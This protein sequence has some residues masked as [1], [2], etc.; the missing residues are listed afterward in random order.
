[1]KILQISKL[2][3]IQEIIESKI[4]ISKLVEIF[5]NS[6]NDWPN[7]VVSLEDFELDVQNIIRTDVTQ[8]SLEIFLSEIN[9][10]KNAW[11]AESLSQLIHIFDYYN[12]KVSLKEII[13]DLK[14]KLYCENLI[15]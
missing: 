6:I 15:D 2:I 14:Q 7:S 3:E 11:Q 10:T 12:D 4:F 13:M 9:L 5:L 1:M 8:K